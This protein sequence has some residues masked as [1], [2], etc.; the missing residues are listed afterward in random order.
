M[1]YLFVEGFDDEKYFSFLFEH[2][3]CN[4][5]E[6]RIIQYSSMKKEKLNNYLYSIKHMPNAKY[7]LVGDCDG[8]TTEK[9]VSY[10][11]Q[12][13]DELEK[14]KI[15]IVHYEIE[16][17]YYAGITNEHCK[18]LKLCHFQYRTDDLTKEQFNSRLEELADRSFVL[19]KILELYCLDYAR[20]RN[21]SLDDSF[22]I[23]Q[24]LFR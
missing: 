18:K 20:E 7:L 13:Y 21:N 17:W 22:P 10:L 15:V 14:E 3:C 12:K 2:Y 6:Y 4:P 9:Q 11:L 19:S 5:L 1:I 24:N 16:S 23:F 8:R